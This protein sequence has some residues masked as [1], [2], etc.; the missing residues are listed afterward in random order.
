MN[1]L[2]IILT[3]FLS[4]NVF[5]QSENDSLQINQLIFDYYESF[6]NRNLNAYKATLSDDYLLIEDGN[7]WDLEEELKY[8]FNPT[9]VKRTNEFE[10]LR[11]DLNLEI[12]IVHYKLKSIYND[13]GNIYEK[14]WVESIVCKKINSSW[15]VSLLHSTPIRGNH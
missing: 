3:L 7:I 15:K 9:T 2:I 13:N 5:A 12:A 6:T 4:V 8:L 11:V 1:R 14:I 10:F